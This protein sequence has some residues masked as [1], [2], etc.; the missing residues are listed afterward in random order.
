M[1]FGKTIIYSGIL[2]LT[3]LNVQAE[4]MICDTDAAQASSIVNKYIVV[5]S[6]GKDP[7][8]LTSPYKLVEDGWKIEHF[9]GSSRN[10]GYPAYQFIF[11][12]NK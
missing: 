4:M 7:A 1:N 11:V 2:T 12:R 8:F 9:T 6:N 5:C 3:A 10:G